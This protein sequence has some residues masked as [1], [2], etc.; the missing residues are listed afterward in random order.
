MGIYLNPGNTAFQKAVNSSIYVDK[1]M[2][3]AYTNKNLN[4]EH[5]EICVSRPRRFGKSMAANMLVAYYSR[6]CNSKELF[7]NLKIASHPDF[8]KHLNKYNVIHLNMQQFLSRTNTIHDMLSMLERKVIRELKRTFSGIEFFEEDLVSIMETLYS[9]TGTQFIFIIDEW[10]CIFRIKESDWNAQKEYLD[11]LRDLLKDQLYVALAYMTGILPIKKY[12]EHSALN[13]FD[14]YSMTNQMALAEFTGFTEEEVRGLCKQYEMSFEETKHWYDG[15]T[16]KGLSIYNPR[17]VVMA[18][19]SHD[20]D[21]YWTKTETYESLKKYIQMNQFGLNK[22]AARLISGEH[23]SVNPDKFQNDM[24]TFN[25]ADDVLTLL[26]HLGYLTYDFCTKTVWIP[27]SEVQREFVNSIE[28]GGWEP[29]MAAIR[30]SEKLLKATLQM[31]EEKVA[32]LVEE[33]HRNNASIIQYNDENSLSCVISLAYYSAKKN[34]AVYREMPGGEGYAD[35]VFVPRI[36][37][38]DPAMIVELKWNKSAET[39]ITQIKNK[40]YAECLQDYS[41]E[42]LLVG[43]SYDKDAKENSKRHICQIEKIMK[44]SVR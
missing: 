10:D 6:G 44:R 22:L 25:S 42:I 1:T 14:E 30:Q 33:A 34:Y 35:L 7:Q 16:L 32:E 2:L 20:F 19:T 31:Q 4:T 15:Y 23:I 18:M 40:K 12:G 39:A 27:N 24:T 9:E 41:G 13:M 37:C 36:G 43:I 17:S 28:D 21:S 5:Q 29:V 26:V 38:S 11:F 8:E 3:I